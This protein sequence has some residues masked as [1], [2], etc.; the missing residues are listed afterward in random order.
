LRE[1]AVCDLDGASPIDELFE[2][3]AGVS[4]MIHVV[5]ELPPSARAVGGASEA[6]CRPEK[7]G[8]LAALA[9]V[10]QA[11]S[12]NEKSLLRGV[13]RRFGPEAQTA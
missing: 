1:H 7:E 13:G 12:S 10:V 5:F 6:K 4:A 3:R 9:N 11:L 2:T 8:P